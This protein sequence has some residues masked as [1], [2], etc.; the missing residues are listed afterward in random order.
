MLVLI[1]I[2][3]G[4]SAAGQVG[5]VRL[6]AQQFGIGV[7]SWQHGNRD[8]DPPRPISD[9]GLSRPDRNTKGRTAK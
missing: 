3:W 1:L 2:A 8:A 7:H 5:A 4:H 9:L 6:Q